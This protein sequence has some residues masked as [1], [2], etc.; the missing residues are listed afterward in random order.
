MML[1]YISGTQHLAMA[2]QQV[3]QR[4]SCTLSSLV[5]SASFS[6]ARMREKVQS[7]PS[8]TKPSGSRETV[9]SRNLSRGRLLS[10]K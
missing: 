4:P 1:G 2:A 8:E 9:S 6:S 10:L 7:R 3:K 5:P